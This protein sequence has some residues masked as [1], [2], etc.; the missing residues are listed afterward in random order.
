MS[1]TQIVVGDKPKLRLKMEDHPGEMMPQV[2]EHFPW[3]KWLERIVR[4]MRKAL[5]EVG[6]WFSRPVLSE[7]PRS[8]AAQPQERP[9]SAISWETTAPSKT[10]SFAEGKNVINAFQRGTTEE[11]E[12]MA[13][14]LVEIKLHLEQLDDQMRRI[15]S[16]TFV[17]VLERV[18]KRIRR[19]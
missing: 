16:K 19:K 6:Q 5:A 2:R 15:E 12:F 8:K 3:K 10:L 11:F 1:G 9:K 14:Y 7:L 13:S 18:W 4:A 17:G